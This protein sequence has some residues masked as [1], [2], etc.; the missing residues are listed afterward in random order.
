MIRRARKNPATV[1]WDQCWDGVDLG[2][3]SYSNAQA[4]PLRRLRNDAAYASTEAS[5]RL[6]AQLD[7]C[8]SASHHT[9]R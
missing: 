5:I 6:C 3:E 7:R 2:P 9:H 4:S 1:G 8:C